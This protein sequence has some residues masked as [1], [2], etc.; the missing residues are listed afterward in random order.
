M[1]LSIKNSVGGT[2]YNNFI[3]IFYFFVRIGYA[4]AQRLGEEGA[5]ILVCSYESGKNNEAVEK[6]RKLGT[7][8]SCEFCD[9]A[10]RDDNKNIV[11]TVIGSS[12]IFD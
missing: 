12:Q 2:K 3:S 11:K 10:K 9:V 5:I 4:L 7:E 1:H 6:L 8:A